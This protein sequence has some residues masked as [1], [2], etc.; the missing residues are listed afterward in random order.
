MDHIARITAAEEQFAKEVVLNVLYLRPPKMWQNLIPGMFLF[1]FLRRGRA[2]RRY[3]QKYM[4]HRRLALNALRELSSGVA[5]QSVE[6]RIEERIENELRPLQLTSA[7]LTLAYRRAVDLFVDHYD[8]L[9]RAH[10]GSYEELVRS[11][12]PTAGEYESHLQ[13]LTEVEKEIDSAIVAALGSG[14]PH[15]EVLKLEAQQVAA[16]RRKVLDRI[17][18]PAG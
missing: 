1:D 17:Y 18:E 7:N 14:T 12:Y 15:G 9:V 10:G 5:R 4:F 13:R 8:R 3:T 11:A 2:I 16:R 6:R